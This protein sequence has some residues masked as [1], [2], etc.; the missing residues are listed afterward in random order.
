MLTAYEIKEEQV[1]LLVAICWILI[2]SGISFISGWYLWLLPSKCT[3][4]TNAIIVR[5]IN[6]SASKRPIFR[7]TTLDGAK[8]EK[9]SIMKDVGFR[10][11]QTVSLKYNPQKPTQCI[12]NG[13]G[14]YKIIGFFLMVIGIAL[15][16]LFLFMITFVL[17]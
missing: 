1:I 10:V 15:F 8:I 3:V 2:L 17:R 11:G 5:V 13:G 16:A 12:M 14:S 9:T 6:V 7:Y 4:S